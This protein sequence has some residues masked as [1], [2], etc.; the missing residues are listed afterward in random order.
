MV[1]KW[2]NVCIESYKRPRLKLPKVMVCNL[3]D[4][5]VRTIEYCSKFVQM[6]QV[7]YISIYYP[8]M[9]AKIRS[10]LTSFHVTQNKENWENS[11]N[12]NAQSVGQFTSFS[13]FSRSAVWSFELNPIHVRSER[14]LSW[15]SPVTL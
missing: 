1:L 6:S 3:T 8:K 11:E 10:I 9:W 7:K 15:N 2:T 5:C 14:P 4:H 12:K 13:L